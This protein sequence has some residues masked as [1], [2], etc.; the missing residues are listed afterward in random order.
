MLLSVN[1]PSSWPLSQLYNRF[2][3]PQHNILQHFS[4][5]QLANIVLFSCLLLGHAVDNVLLHFYGDKDF[6]KFSGRLWFDFTCLPPLLLSDL[7]PGVLHA[8]VLSNTVRREALGL[9]ADQLCT[10]LWWEGLWQ[11]PRGSQFTLPNL[12][13]ILTLGSVLEWMPQA[14]G[15]KFQ[16][17]S[18]K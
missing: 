10:G 14:L 6:F 2:L 16:N 7:G 8:D 13:R 11:P 4:G 1:T 15:Y 18:T 9:T 5:F 12:I 17:S 3:T